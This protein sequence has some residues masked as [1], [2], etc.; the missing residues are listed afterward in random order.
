M[1]P[2]S[3]LCQESTDKFRIG[4]GYSPYVVL[5]KEKVN[6]IKGTYSNSFGLNG[7]VKTAK[8]FHQMFY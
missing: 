6:D 2:F 8:I 4:I 1:L 5:K 7:S 3:N